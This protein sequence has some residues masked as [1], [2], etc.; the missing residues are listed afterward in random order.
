MDELTLREL[1]VLQCAANG[2]DINGTCKE[3]HLAVGTVKAIRARITVKL[4]ATH[5]AHA[6]AIAIRKG[7]IE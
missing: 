6:V 5:I 4:K 2:L 7:I 1:Q 3:L